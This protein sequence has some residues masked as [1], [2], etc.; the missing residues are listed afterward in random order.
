MAAAA[1][2][3]ATKATVDSESSEKLTSLSCDFVDG[4]N[5]DNGTSLQKEGENCLH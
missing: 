5:T 1:A 3:A 4:A 2:G